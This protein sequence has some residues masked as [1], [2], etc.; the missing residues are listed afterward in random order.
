MAK[1]T[2]KLKSCVLENTFIP[3]LL[4]VYLDNFHWMAIIATP[5][6]DAYDTIVVYDH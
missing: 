2:K 4:I 5:L 1:W 3:N 6:S